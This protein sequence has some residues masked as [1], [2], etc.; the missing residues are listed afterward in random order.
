MKKFNHTVLLA[1]FLVVVATSSC[2]AEEQSDEF[3]ESVKPV[4][5]DQEYPHWGIKVHSW[6]TGTGA[7]TVA[8]TQTIDATTGT[9][10]QQ[11]DRNCG[12]SDAASD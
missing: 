5:L 7:N 2:F 11:I 6:I 12:Y 8:H 4:V 9:I 1:T 3:I 10:I